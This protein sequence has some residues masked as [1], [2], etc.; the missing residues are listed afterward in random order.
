VGRGGLCY[1]PAAVEGSTAFACRYALI[2]A[3]VAAVAVGGCG[4]G[5]RQD[6]D[7]PSGTF[8]VDVVNTSFPTK[9]HLAQPERFVIAVRNTGS[10]T[11]PN[12]AVTVSSFA[13]RSEQ[14]GLADPE[15]AVWVIDASP[16][17]GDTA[18]T[19]T[20]ALGR[21]APGQTRRFVWRVTAVQAGTHT[22][23]WEVAAGLNGKAKA[24]L[25]GNRAPAGSVTVDVSSKPAQ[26]HVD[27][28][29]GRVV[30]ESQ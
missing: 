1:V 28:K 10:R 5:K 20:W 17:G 4:G 30:R 19:N 24:T 25:A 29:T 21:L 8:Q 12:V 26:A 6:A 13:A 27:P 14:A 23:K 18:Y 7:E 2:A 16:R 3:S 11:V 9:Q 22:V 15:R